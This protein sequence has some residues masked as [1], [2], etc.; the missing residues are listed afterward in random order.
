[1]RQ[2]VTAIEYIRGV[3]MMGVVGIHTGAYSLSHPA[4]NI[5]LFALLEIASRF[6]VPIFFFV[7]AFGLFWHHRPEA[8][9]D[10]GAFYRRRALT[11]A[12]P[13]VAWSLLYMGHASWT[14]GE[15]WMW[16]QPYIWEHLLFGLGSYQLY[17][18]VIL[19]WFYAL[20]PMWR[21][22]VP[23]LA[24]RPLP[25]LGALLVAQIAFNYWSC[26][27]LAVATDNYYVNLAI[28]HRLSYWVLHYV[29]VFMLGGV[30][31]ARFADF[32]AL[33]ARHHRAL[34]AFFTASL[35]LMLAAY[36]WLLYTQDYVPEQAVNTVQQLSP[37]GVVYTLAAGLFLFA[38]FDR[39]LPVWA[40]SPLSLLA[41]HSYAVYLVH[42]LV[43]EYLEKGLAAAGM[44][45]TPPV[46]VAF[47]AGTVAGSLLFG[48]ALA[49]AAAAAPTVGTLLTG[50]YAK[51]KA[52]PGA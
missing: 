17:F 46:V 35:A 51:P 11:V 5:H 47:Y 22:A 4:V 18:L 13:Y 14:S 32:A 31:A 50:A 26:Y 10:W 39:P 41:R 23:Y 7:S 2:R 16:E 38:L 30:C 21:M 28:D 40:T 48:A 37:P 36:Y 20:M 9:V 49:R 12:V 29:F 34:A 6:S 15:T 19:I 3:A 25:R 1:M 33:A 43:M 24:A 27:V 42:P 45:M 8:P 52:R 44:A